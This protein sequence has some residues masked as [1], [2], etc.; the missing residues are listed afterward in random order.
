MDVVYLNETMSIELSFLD[1]LS[2]FDMP[3]IPTNLFLWLVCNDIHLQ[4]TALNLD[5]S[6]KK[7]NYSW[8]VGLPYIYMYKPQLYI[9]GELFECSSESILMD[10]Q[11]GE[12]Q[13]ESFLDKFDIHKRNVEASAVYLTNVKNVQTLKPTLGIKEPLPFTFYYIFSKYLYLYII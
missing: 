4:D 2:Q 13:E 7:I 6:S 1:N 9:S 11:L 10:S 5:T 12:V 3:F 8:L